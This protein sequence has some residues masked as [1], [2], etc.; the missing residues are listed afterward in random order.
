MLDGFNTI[1]RIMYFPPQL[2]PNH[3]WRFAN[4]IRAVSRHDLSRQLVISRTNSWS[5]P[6]GADYPNFGVSILA[7]T[8][9]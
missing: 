2:R 8:V 5:F 4:P 7:G 6:G 9:A 3:S 1:S